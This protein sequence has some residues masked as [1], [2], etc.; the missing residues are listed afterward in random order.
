MRT[1][2]LWILTGCL[3]GSP[4]E[5]EGDDPAECRDGADND[6][7][8]LFDCFDDDCSGSP[9]CVD[10]GGVGLPPGPGGNTNGSTDPPS[11]TTDWDGSWAPGTAIPDLLFVD[12]SGTDLSLHDQLGDYTLIDVQTMWTGP[13][14]VLAS[15]TPALVDR[16]SP[17]GLS[18]ITVLVEDIQGDDPTAD[19]LLEW[20][21]AFTLTHPVVR[22][23]SGHTATL[24]PAWPQILLLD[25]QGV[26]LDDTLP[27]DPSQLCATLAGVTGG[28]SCDPT[29]TM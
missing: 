24:G 25:D 14:Q 16:F 18:W 7:D 26:V 9:D 4:T 20:T 15:E 2:P 8:G 11:G 27:S 1:W 23:P 12:A 21:N 17:Y 22:D 10:N 19:D 5:F 13:G 3:M 29:S 28:P 6:L